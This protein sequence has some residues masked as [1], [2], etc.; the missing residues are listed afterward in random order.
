M[1]NGR[2]TRLH[3]FP[4]TPPTGSREWWRATAR[5]RGGPWAMASQCA[6]ESQRE[7]VAKLQEAMAT[8]LI[9]LGVRRL[10]L[11]GSQ[12]RGDAKPQSDVDVLVGFD[13]FH[14]DFLNSRYEVGGGDLTQIRSVQRVD[15]RVSA[16]GRVRMGTELFAI[17]LLYTFVHNVSS[18]STLFSYSRHIAG[19]EVQFNF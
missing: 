7:I 4:L 19:L 17:S 16:Y 9:G 13:Y 5:G 18:A 10:A 6:S 3:L 1:D 11:F 2:R 15:D 14:R 8:S 12:A